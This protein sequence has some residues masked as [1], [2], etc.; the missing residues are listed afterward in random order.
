[1]VMFYVRGKVSI[2]GAPGFQPMVMNVCAYEWVRLPQD[3]W[4]FIPDTKVVSR[5][6]SAA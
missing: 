6:S 2:H 5:K 3:G 4:E 1:M